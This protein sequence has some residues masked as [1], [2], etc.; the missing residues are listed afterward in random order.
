[1]KEIPSQYTTRFGI[2]V[3]CPVW[4]P[5]A[6]LSSHLMFKRL[7]TSKIKTVLETMSSQSEGWPSLTNLVFDE[8]P[9]DSKMDSS[10]VRASKHS[11]KIPALS[12]G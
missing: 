9:F 5:G 4:L 7:D 6:F 8:L 11:G 12:G 1:M 3:T 2:I 10:F